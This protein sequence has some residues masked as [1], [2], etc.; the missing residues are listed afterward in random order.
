MVL[1]RTSPASSSDGCPVVDW[2]V[3][4]RRSS[5]LP[6]NPGADAQNGISSSNWSLSSCRRTVGQN[7]EAC[8]NNIHPLNTGLPNAR[9]SVDEIDNEEIQL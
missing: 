5:R 3:M 2:L 4:I 8:D 6:T 9:V 1:I 7:M